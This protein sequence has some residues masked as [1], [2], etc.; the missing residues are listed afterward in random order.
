[1]KD[2]S[3]KEKIQVINTIIDRLKWESADYFICHSAF[4]ILNNTNTVDYV[5]KKFEKELKKYFP[6][7]L[8]MILIVGKKYSRKFKFG[9]S[10]MINQIDDVEIKKNYLRELIKTL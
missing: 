4:K 2:L 10:W 6:E 7:L 9:H 8:N 5:E 1:M 3:K